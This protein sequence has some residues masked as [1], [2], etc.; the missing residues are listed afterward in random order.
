ML[1]AGDP[2]RIVAIFDWDM[3][4]LGDPLADVGALLA[5]WSEPTDPAYLQGISM[6]PTGVSG[7]PT[8]AEL[9]ERYAKRSG[10]SVNDIDFYHALGL[11]RL[12]VILA[13]IYIRYVRGQ[14]HDQR[15]TAF[16]PTIPLL[17]KAAQAV[18][19]AQSP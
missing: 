1:A 13:Q 10:R 8:R 15:F 19:F 2:S 16:G 9:I 3:C 4:T 17:A 5:Y 14:T 11:F 7:F 12:T 18:A 6:M